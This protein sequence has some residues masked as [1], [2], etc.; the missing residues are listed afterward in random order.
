MTYKKNR[1]TI[2]ILPL[3]YRFITHMNNWLHVLVFFI[4]KHNCFFSRKF[5]AS[6]S[7]KRDKQGLYINWFYLFEII[8]SGEVV[9][10]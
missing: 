5:N 3:K 6:M 10:V 7:F 4:E 9:M 2:I 1:Q 8:T